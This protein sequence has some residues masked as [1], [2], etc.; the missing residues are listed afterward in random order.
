MALE[1][2]HRAELKR[3]LDRVHQLME[4]GDDGIEMLRALRGMFFHHRMFLIHQSL[5]SMPKY[6]VLLDNGDVLGYAEWFYKK[7]IGQY[8]HERVG[9]QLAAATRYF[10]Q[11]SV[12]QEAEYAS[13]KGC[14]WSDGLRG[15]SGSGYVVF[16]EHTQ[17]WIEWEMEAANSGPHQ[18]AF[19][20]CLPAGTAQNLQ[21]RAGDLKAPMV[22]QPT[23]P[24]AWATNVI[25]VELPAGHNRIKLSSSGTGGLE[26]DYLDVQGMTSQSE[27]KI[28]TA[29]LQQTNP[30]ASTNKLAAQSLGH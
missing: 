14:H 13:F 17:S 12:H 21:L 26:L 6:S 2:M 4:Q 10:W 7:R 8:N 11:P 1:R 25:A 24:D 9:R 22:F 20:Y 28:P 30:T 18:L 15:F 16:E 29:G 27:P 23:S 19:R 3:Y 5:F